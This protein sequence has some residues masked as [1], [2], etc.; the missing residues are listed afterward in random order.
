MIASTELELNH[1]TD[2]GGE[3][4]RAESKRGVGAGNRDDVNLLGRS[5]TGQ[6]SDENR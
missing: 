3:V 4:I 1:V 5:Q 2:V 6:G